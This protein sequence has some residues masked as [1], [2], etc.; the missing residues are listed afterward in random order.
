MNTDAS[1]DTAPPKS[2]IARALC[3][4]NAIARSQHPLGV[5]TIARETGL[6]KA[7]AHRIL[8]ELVAE[9]FLRFNEDT[10]FYRLGPGALD[11]GLAALRDLDVIAVAHRHLV[12][13][14]RRAGTTST[15][16]VLQG[17]SR[18]YVDQVLASQEIR[19]SVALGSVH[20]LHAGSSSKA[21]LAALP[22][23]EV[24]DYISHHRLDSLTEATITS[25]DTL[26]QE[27]RRIRDLG[28][29]ASSEERQSGASSVAAAIYGATGR[30]IGA[31]SVCGPPDMFARTRREELGSLVAETAATVSAELGHRPGHGGEGEV[32]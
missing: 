22:D 23:H 31:L 12:A 19:M 10:K 13:L 8:R 29:A 6:S 7:V 20:P 14:S 3:V 5:S 28:Y 17:W 4:I 25:A 18:V 15:L 21:I 32:A 26:R 2:G 16:S 24:A 1:T 9:D 11:I 30:V 27:I